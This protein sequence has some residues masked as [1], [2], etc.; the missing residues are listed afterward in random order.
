MA[1]VA[2]TGPRLTGVVWGM[3]IDTEVVGPEAV[4]LLKGGSGTTCEITGSTIPSVLDETSS[5][6]DAEELF[7]ILDI[8]FL[9]GG[10]FLL[11]EFPLLSFMH[12]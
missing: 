4:V 9:V 3:G 10:G 5:T 11:V 2:T 8:R 12:F 6:F 7:V 1:L